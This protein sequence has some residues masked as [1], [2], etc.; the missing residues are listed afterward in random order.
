MLTLKNIGNFTPGLEIAMYHSIADNPKDPWAIHPDK[1]RQQLTTL[2][3]NGY[4]IIGL[5]AALTKHSS[6]S[7]QNRKIVLTFDDAYVDFLTNA[8]PIL[9]ELNLPATVF[10]PTGL[11]GGTSTWDSHDRTKRLMDWD[12]LAEIEKMGF[13]LGSHTVSHHRLPRCDL[14]QLEHE[15][16]HSLEDLQERFTHIVQALSY[17]FGDY[18]NREILALKK[19]GYQAAL[20]IHNPWRNFPWTNPFRLRR[21][22]L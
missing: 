8:A 18:G 12:E 17:P 9:N 5:K 2:L 21:C 11:V 13:T 1:F 20:G 15:I 16:R 6:R 10:V 4:Q 19:A 7:L 22:L 3:D 14:K